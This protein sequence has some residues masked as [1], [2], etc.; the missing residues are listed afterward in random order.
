MVSVFRSLVAVRSF[1]QLTISV[2]SAKSRSVAARKLWTGK[3]LPTDMTS[4]L[5]RLRRKPGQALRGSA[6]SMLSS[7]RR[8]T[9]KVCVGSGAEPSDISGIDT[10]AGARSACCLRAHGG[11]FPASRA[12]PCQWESDHHE[13]KGPCRFGTFRVFDV[14]TPN[15]G[16]CPGAASQGIARRSRP[17]RRRNITIH[18]RKCGV[19]GAGAIAAVRCNALY[20]LRWRSVNQ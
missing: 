7:P 10:D 13:Q 6:A 17:G 9:T 2:S 18:C 12:K 5:R 14:I 16:R 20:L 19:R 11:R 1:W 4:E 8:L 15:M 3:R